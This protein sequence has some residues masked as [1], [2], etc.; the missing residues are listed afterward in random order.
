MQTSHH[1]TATA[2]IKLLAIVMTVALAVVVVVSMRR[3]AAAQ[4]AKQKAGSKAAAKG[5]E[6]KPLEKELEQ[7]WK[8]D[9]LPSLS[10]GVVRGGELVYA[11]SFGLA[12]RR[13]GRAATPD[14]SYRI[15]SITKV[16]TTTLLAALRDRGIV[17]LDDPVARYLPPDVKLP[18]DPTG[19]PAITLRHLATHSSGLPRLPINLVP[20]AGDPYGG[21]SVQLLY[22]GLA[23][24]RLDFATGTRESYSNLGAGL[25]GHAL[26]RAAGEPYE[27]LIKKHIFEPLGMKQSTITLSPEHRK[28]FAT[29]YREDATKREAV[30]WDLGCL[31]PAGAIA[32][33]ITDMARFLALQLQ[34]GESDA[35]KGAGAARVPSAISAST[36][37]EMH[38]PQKLADGSAMHVGL[39]WV[40][41]P[42]EHGGDVIWHNGGMEGFH[43][44]LGFSP[45]HKIGVIVLTN[46]GKDID[47]LGA[48]LLSEVV[49][50]SGGKP[51]READPA[52]RNIAESLSKHFVA[53][54]P[55]SIAELFHEQF[56]VAVPLTQI[57]PLFA[58]IFRQYG[59][60]EGVEVVAG[61]KPR[62]GTIRFKFAKNKTVRGQIGLD[63]G[64]PPKIVSLL[65]RP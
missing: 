20:K 7:R 48:W 27:T 38:T 3:L 62:A 4:V 58:D 9:G 52:L 32:S 36:L 34:A 51:S 49:Q 29:G 41:Q 18:S 59:R 63:T 22:D 21:Y 17:G 28:L 60:C 61:D 30:D 16:F 55:D 39:G 5:P 40:V 57:K 45:K 24:T 44:Y 19:A 10:V 12:D 25:L 43:S 23:K 31:A 64:N 33:P 15:G 42:F 11:K 35:A 53:N 6:F 50:P 13:S 37:A 65:M 2:S 14:T 56:L 47:A 1:V 46:S 8:D 54:P 26:E